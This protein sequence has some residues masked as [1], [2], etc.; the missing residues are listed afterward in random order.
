M[1]LV[2]IPKGNTDTRGIGLLESL[3]KVLEAIIYTRLRESVCLHNVLHGFRAVMGTRAAVLELN[4]AQEL[5]RV[6]QDPLFL[7]FL[8]L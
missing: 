4:V 1:I 8:Y 6:N 3:W 7:V 5:A 2:L